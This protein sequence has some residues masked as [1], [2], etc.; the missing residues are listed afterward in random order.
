[1]LMKMSK[2][3]S[4]MFTVS[5]CLGSILLAIFVAYACDSL[6]EAMDKA[7]ENYRN[8]LEA[9]IDYESHYL[10]DLMVEVILVGALSGG[11][12]KFTGKD[13]ISAIAKGSAWGAGAYLVISGWEIYSTCTRLQGKV[14]EKASTYANARGAYEDCLN[15]PAKYTYTCYY[16]NT[17]YEFG[18]DTYGS[19]GAAYDAYMNFIGVHAH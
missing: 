5:I 14:D 2:N 16:C 17:V 10:G 9:L 12:V 4:V 19:D 18:A 1:M 11:G 6:K 13:A 8:A 15:P 7:G 3:K